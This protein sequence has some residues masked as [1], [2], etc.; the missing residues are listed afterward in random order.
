MIIQAEIRQIQTF[1][2]K[3]V[4]YAKIGL[5]TTFPLQAFEIRINQQ[6]LDQGILEVFKKYLHQSV[7]LPIS[8]SLYK[9]FIQYQLPF[10]TLCS[11]IH[12]VV[13]LPVSEP[14]KPVKNV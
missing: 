9:G 1:F 2:E 8:V 10:D 12:P 5:E 11:S 6:A 3:E 13:S 14:L 7:Y 4:H